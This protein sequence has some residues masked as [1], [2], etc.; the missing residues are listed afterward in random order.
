MNQKLLE[1]IR[2]FSK[3]ILFW[4]PKQQIYQ[5]LQIKENISFDDSMNSVEGVPEI[6]AIYSFESCEVQKKT[7]EL[8]V[9]ENVLYIYKS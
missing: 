3:L 1:E 9:W 8:Y 2:Y 4:T 5:P 6:Q 7:F